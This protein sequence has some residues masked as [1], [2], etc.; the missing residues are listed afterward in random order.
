MGSNPTRLAALG[1]DLGG[2]LTG[3]DA[4]GTA[5]DAT[6]GFDALGRTWQRNLTGSTDTYSFVG[7]T[8][9]VARISNSSGPVVTDSIVDV[10]GDRLGVKQGSTVNW[11]LPDPHGDIA[12]SLSSTETTVVNAI[13]YDAYGQTIATGSAG[14]TAVGQANWKYQ[15]RLDVSPAGLAT[16]LYDAGARFYAPGTGTFTSLDSV[17]GSA[18]D[19]LSMNRFLYAEA[20]PTTLIDPS[21]HCAGY[22]RAI[23]EGYCA[24]VN[25]SIAK[26]GHPHGRSRSTTSGFRWRSERRNDPK[27][28]SRRV[29]TLSHKLSSDDVVA[30][31]K[32]WVA[33]TWD[34]SSLTP[35]QQS[36][37]ARVHGGD[38]LNWLQASAGTDAALSHPAAYWAADLRLSQLVMS[39]AFASDNPETE[40]FA[41]YVS[42]AMANTGVPL[43]DFVGFDQAQAFVGSSDTSGAT[44]EEIALAG[45]VLQI[46]T[47]LG[48][49]PISGPG[50]LSGRPSVSGMG[51]E[52]Y[53]DGGGARPLNL[54]PEGAGRRGAFNKAKR[55]HGVPTS[56]QPT[57]VGPNID[58]RGNR[59]PGRTY[60]FDV[61]G[62]GTVIIRDD[63][64][65]HTYGPRD[66]QNRGPHFNVE[67]NDHYDY[68]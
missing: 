47:G 10:A 68:G 44:A 18:Q 36:G 23:D 35:E 46:Y 55:A 53:G 2:K 15:G 19:P 9:T 39:G 59:V 14:G 29:N 65:G 40:A 48:D 4:A 38:A 26:T 17:M 22:T 27:S 51:P 20:N 1:Y 64:T 7:S 21:G 50:E 56:M 41:P 60:E 43:G 54:S 45:T 13:R 34:W 24:N 31:T 33:P 6:F 28:E 58:N 63:A 49:P 11:F 12:A 37:Y 42:G 16:P 62:V 25:Y 57:R 5:N 3:I 67:P 32:K 30:K 66:P 8:E 52:Y 61:P